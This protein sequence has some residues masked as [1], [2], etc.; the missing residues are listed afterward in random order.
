[1]MSPKKGDRTLARNKVKKSA[2]SVP[3][4]Y[5]NRHGEATDAL[6]ADD[7]I[8]SD[9]GSMIPSDHQLFASGK[10]VGISTNL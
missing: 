5:H 7:N 4:P 6:H 1:M 2:V 9:R 8:R 3:E 10:R